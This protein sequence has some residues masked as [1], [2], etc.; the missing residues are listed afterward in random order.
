[1]GNFNFRFVGSQLLEYEQDAGG[2]SLILLQAAESGQIPATYPIAGFAD[3]IRKDGNQEYRANFTVA[4]NKGDFG[5][6]ATAYYIGDFYQDSLTI[7]DPNNPGEILQYDVPSMTTVNT[8]ADYTFH[9]SDNYSLRAPYWHQQHHG[10]T[11]TVSGSILRLLRGF[12]SRS[13][14]ILL[15]RPE[16]KLLSRSVIG[17]RKG[18]FAPFLL[19]VCLSAASACATSVETS[20]AQPEIPTKVLFCR[21]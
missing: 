20:Q 8:K 3:L 14:S 17:K 7:D 1:M 21:Q 15:P 2:D 12:A 10:R 18:G 16:A 13:R 11:C 4:Y 6:S 9:P 5:A 19:A